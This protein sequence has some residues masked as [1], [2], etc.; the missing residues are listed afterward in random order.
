M[1]PAPAR[2]DAV[3]A[4]FD[5]TVLTDWPLNPNEV[6]HGAPRARG[7]VVWRSTDET[8]AA[9]FWAC[10]AGAFVRNYAWTETA[11]VLSGSATVSTP[12]AEQ[13]LEP[14]ALLVLPVGI[15]ASWSIQDSIQTAFHLAADI[16]LP[17]GSDP[18]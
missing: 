14:G 17:L 11:L 16:P 10:S 8:R 5:D 6:K 2:A 15:T 7:A 12:E 18:L 4:A 9:G 3:L 13:R 1:A